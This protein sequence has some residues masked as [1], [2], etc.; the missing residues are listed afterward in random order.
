MNKEKKV[1]SAKALLGF[2]IVEDREAQYEAEDEERKG[3]KNKQ[4]RD[5]NRTELKDSQGVNFNYYFSEKYQTCLEK[6][7]QRIEQRKNERGK[8]KDK[9]KLD[10]K[11][12]EKRGEEGIRGKGRGRGERGRGRGRG[13]R[14]GKFGHEE[15]S[16]HADNAQTGGH[17]PE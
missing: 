14:G 3:R 8:G 6:K 16:K 11:E 9:G 12:E 17:D 2:D 7:R 1:V 15:E 5:Y 13:G 4:K 10:E